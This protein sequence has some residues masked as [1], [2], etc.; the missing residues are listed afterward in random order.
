M[1]RNVNPTIVNPNDKTLRP[2]NSESNARSTV[3]PAEIVSEVIVFFGFLVVIE[4]EMIDHPAS[5][6][7][8]KRWASNYRA[9][10]SPSFRCVVSKAGV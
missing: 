5:D 2:R 9:S 3:I 1:K 4:I 7:P 8:A 6:M 10:K